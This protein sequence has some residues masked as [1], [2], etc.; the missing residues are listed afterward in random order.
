MHG[1]PKWKIASFTSV[2]NARMPVYAHCRPRSISCCPCKSQV[3]WFA[4]LCWYWRPGCWFAWRCLRSLPSSFFSASRTR[5]YSSMFFTLILSPSI[6]TLRG[7]P[8]A[9]L[10][11]TCFSST[12]QYIFGL[13]PTNS[14]MRCPLCSSLKM[15]TRQL[16][17]KVWGTIPIKGTFSCQ[18][19]ERTSSR[20][21]HKSRLVLSSSEK[22]QTTCTYRTSC[23][24]CY[25]DR[26]TVRWA[27]PCPL[28]QQ[29]HVIECVLE[30]IV[31]EI[32]DDVLGHVEN[33]KPDEERLL[34]PTYRC[35]S[36]WC[37]S[38]FQ[39]TWCGSCDHVISM[40]LDDGLHV[41][42]MC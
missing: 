7:T 37:Q 26:S 21:V 1:C 11:T 13:S 14:V 18:L 33:G 34:H 16:L 9:A 27:N 17:V 42:S 31:V 19:L 41:H 24:R 5:L 29:F 6:T 36:I 40:L 12:R 15:G 30:H 23:G 10:C 39:S 28:S 25:H 38:D 3:S 2:Y 22:S 4:P 32:V 35:N 20:V 8:F